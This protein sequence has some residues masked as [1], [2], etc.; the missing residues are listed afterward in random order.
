M[1]S[2]RDIGPVSKFLR[3]IYRSGLKIFAYIT[4]SGFKIF[5]GLVSEFLRTSGFGIFA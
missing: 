4:T 1:L 2:D 5:T 3:M